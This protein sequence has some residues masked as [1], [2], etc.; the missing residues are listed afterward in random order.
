MNK[1]GSWA[2]AA[3]A[4]IACISAGQT[5]MAL[6]QQQAQER[7]RSGPCSCAEPTRAAACGFHAS[8]GSK[9]GS[10][11]AGS[12]GRGRA[13]PPGPVAGAAAVR[14]HTP[15]DRPLLLQELV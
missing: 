8:R 15:A 12:R 9:S 14:R 4:I 5:R 11:G 1:L 10:S 3:A 13:S 6:A 7:G 2:F